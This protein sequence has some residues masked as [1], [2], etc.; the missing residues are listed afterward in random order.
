MLSTPRPVSSSRMNVL[1][2]RIVDCSE[3][4]VLSIWS[5]VWF[6]IFRSDSS[7]VCKIG[8]SRGRAAGSASGP[9]SGSGSLGR[10][11]CLHS[12]KQ[13][14]GS[15]LQ[16]Q[17]LVLSVV[18][19]LRVRQLPCDQQMDKRREQRKGGKWRVRGPGVDTPCSLLGRPGSS[20][21]IHMVE[22]C[23]KQLIMQLAGESAGQP[24]RTR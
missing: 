23:G 12:A 4:H 24:E 15:G 10:T 16:A 5:S 3:N 14:A 19:N 18:R 22:T 8:T 21:P 6:G 11:A 17:H 20:I 7:P 2:T 1:C 9:K 13:Q